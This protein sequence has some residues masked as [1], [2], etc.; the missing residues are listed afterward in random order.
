MTRH[1]HRELLKDHP[2]F[3]VP[4]VVDELCSPHVL[5]TELV[6]GFPLDQAEGLSQEIRNEVRL[7]VA[8]GAGAACPPLAPGCTLGTKCH[9]GRGGA[10]SQGSPA[11][12]SRVTRLPLPPP[13]ICHNILVL[14]LRELFEFHFMQTDPNWSNFFY[15]PEQHKVS[16]WVGAWAGAPWSGGSAPSC[17]P[18]LLSPCPGGSPGLRGNSGI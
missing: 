1:P 5:T 8:R 11:L 7:H 10:G 16:P 6:S 14:C 17:K 9:L 3:Y 4:E 2:F 18:A 13:Q 15:D 12:D